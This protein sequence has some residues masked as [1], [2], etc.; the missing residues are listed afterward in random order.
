MIKKYKKTL[1][2]SSLALLIPV[3]VSIYLLVSGIKSGLW[4]LAVPGF[5]GVLFFGYLDAKYFKWWIQEG[6]F[7]AETSFLD[8]IPVLENLPI[9][10]GDIM[11]TL[12]EEEQLRGKLEDSHRCLNSRM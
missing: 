2:A 6:R 12:P 9:P 4:L 11:S 3:I 10:E 5:A 7:G 1:I 8:D